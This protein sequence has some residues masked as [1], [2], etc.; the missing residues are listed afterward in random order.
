VTEVKRKAK[1]PTPVNPNK[2]AGSSAS[3]TSKLVEVQG[4][5]RIFLG[6]LPGKPKA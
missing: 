1:K 5:R 6:G 4:T 2:T 3:T